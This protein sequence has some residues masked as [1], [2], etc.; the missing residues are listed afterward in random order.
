MKN[1]HTPGPW[2]A[3][4]LESY[5]YVMADQGKRWDNPTICDLFEDVTPETSVTIGAW[6]KAYDNA[7][8]NARLIAEAPAMADLIREFFLA[9]PVDFDSMNR[10]TVEQAQRARAILARIDG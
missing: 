2:K 4:D 10:V 3:L 1:A 5:P 7:K 9:A 6:L 8:A